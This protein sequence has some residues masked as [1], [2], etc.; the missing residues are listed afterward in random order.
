MGIPVQARTVTLL[1]QK[2]NQD[3]LL[4]NLGE[5]LL[6]QQNLLALLLLNKPFRGTKSIKK[7]ISTRPGKGYNKTTDKPRMQKSKGLYR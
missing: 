3:L 4:L 6:L 7:L 1:S 5:N 2:E